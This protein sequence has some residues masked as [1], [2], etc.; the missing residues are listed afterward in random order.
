M[1][2]FEWMQLANFNSGRRGK[3]AEIFFEPKKLGIEPMLTTHGTGGWKLANT[4]V[5]GNILWAPLAP[6]E[7]KTLPCHSGR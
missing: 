3:F 4:V 5:G 1:M 7:G 2:N 6:P